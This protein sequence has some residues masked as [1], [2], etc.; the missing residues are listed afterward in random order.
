MRAILIFIELV[1]GAGILLGKILLVGI[2][3]AAVV[4]VIV[5]PSALGFIVLAVCVLGLLWVL[6]DHL[7][8]KKKE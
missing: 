8:R 2:G 7:K 3:A 6:Y 1:I 4:A 5:T